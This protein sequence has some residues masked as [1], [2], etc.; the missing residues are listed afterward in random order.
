MCLGGLLC[1][2]GQLGPSQ[3]M[4]LHT[5]PRTDATLLSFICVHDLGLQ[6]GAELLGQRAH[7]Y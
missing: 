4:P 3:H 7:Q 1:S 2:I 6:P 5:L